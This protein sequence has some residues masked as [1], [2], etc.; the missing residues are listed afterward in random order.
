[1]EK[2][3]EK[4]TLHATIWMNDFSLHVIKTRLFLFIFML[5]LK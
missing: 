2:K 5:L 3:K 1:M 4:K